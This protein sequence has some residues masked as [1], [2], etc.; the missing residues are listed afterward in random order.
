ME[1]S[2]GMVRKRR[3]ASQLGFRV[4]ARS[5]VLGSICLSSRVRTHSRT[6][7]FPPGLA[8]SMMARAMAAMTRPVWAASWRPWF[9]LPSIGSTGLAAASW[10]SAATS[11]RLPPSQD[12][13]GWASPGYTAVPFCL[14]CLAWSF[15]V[16]PNPD[17]L[18][19]P[20]TPTLAPTGGLVS[21]PP[22]SAR[23][24][25]QKRGRT[26]KNQALLPYLDAN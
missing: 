19:W 17:S 13:N 26:V 20:K 22:I 11:R 23:P 5:A 21:P 18:T 24:R 15:C 6:F 8:W 16:S 2:G 4:K 7:S 25:D 14:T 10:S 12:R 1:R 3:L 9:R